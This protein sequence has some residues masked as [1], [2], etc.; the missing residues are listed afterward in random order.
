M[1]LAVT[2]AAGAALLSLTV[3]AYAQA[4]S[5]QVDREGSATATITVTSESLATLTAEGESPFN[6]SFSPEQ[7]GPGVWQSTMTLLSSG[8]APGGYD[9]EVLVNKA[10]AG[11]PIA[12]SARQRLLAEDDLMGRQRGLSN[13]LAA[14][15]RAVAEMPGADQGGGPVLN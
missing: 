13:H 6:V 3:G 11:L 10:C 4:V 2:V 9:F 1:K 5:M 7:G 14:V 15:I 12:A 8:T